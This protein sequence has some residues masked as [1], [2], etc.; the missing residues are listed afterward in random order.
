METLDLNRAIK[1]KFTIDEQLEHMKN[2]GVRFNIYSEERARYYLQENTY[3]FKLKAYEKL[4]ER[5]NIPEK[6][7][8]FVNLEFAYLCDLATIDCYLR[9][10]I[11]SI[12]LDIEHY[13]KV[14]LLNDFNNSEEDGYQIV[15]DFIATSPVYYQ[16]EIEHKMEGKACSN[17]VK[18]Y[19]SNWA[20]WNFIE[21]M[22][23]GD[24]SQFYGFFYSRNE[25]FEE[26]KKMGYLINP[27]RILRNA[28]AHNNCLLHT[29][30]VPYVSE[31]KFNRNFRVNSFLGKNGIKQRTL[32]LNMSRPMVHDFCVM[33]FLYHKIAPIKVQEFTFERLALFFEKR[34]SLHSEYYECNGILIS[35]YRFMLSVIK[36][37][38]NIVQNAN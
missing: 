7:N 30:K 18:K 21:V 28:A 13:L 4:F 34:V 25:D 23:F 2:K 19:S 16:K 27:V 33:L 22:S 24:F 38:L 6:K 10:E 31:E 15:K 17:L 29:L 11:M 35:S 36:M 26:S 9:K 5:Y 32:N 37:F 3:Y 8:Q 14:R 12:S 1:P 20:I